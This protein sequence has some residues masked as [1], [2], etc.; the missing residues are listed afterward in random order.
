MVVAKKYVLVKNY[1][2]FPSD[3]NIELQEET[4]QALQD[5]EVL[6]E[7]TFLTVDPY[8]RIFQP[9]G[10]TMVGEQVGKVVESKNPS[11]KSGDLYRASFGWRSHTLCNPDADESKELKISKLMD[12]GGLSPSLAMGAAGMPGE[13]AY[14]GLFDK[15]ALKEGDVVMVTGAAGAVGSIVGQIAKIK[16][17]RV[18]GC[19]GTDDKCAWLKTLGFDHVF[20]YKTAD[21]ATELKAAAPN[22]F[23]VFF[24]NV[25]GHMGGSVINNHMASGGRVVCVGNISGYNS[26]EPQCGPY[27]SLSIL[28]NLLTVRGMVHFTEPEETINTAKM[29]LL[30]WIQEGKLEA[31]EHITEGFDNMREAFYGLFSGANTGKAIVKV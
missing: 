13:T 10:A 7:A 1:E 31:R 25:G 23:N 9:V 24:D 8:M 18:V 3:E 22:G 29:Q 14:I 4:L 6:F 2:G 21:L 5:G 17:C 11:W 28:L 27:F 30:K 16:N 12:M 20:N 19:A 15:C 26:A